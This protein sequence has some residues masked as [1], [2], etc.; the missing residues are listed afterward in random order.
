MT[1]RAGAAIA[2]W[3]AF[4]SACFWVVSR[5][6]YTADLSAFLPRTPTQEQQLLID[7]LKSG[8]ASRLILI[9]IEGG[10][11]ATRAR[12]SRAL[13]ARLRADPQFLN[14]ANGETLGLERDRQFLLENRYLLSPAV[15]ADRFTVEGLRAGVA[16]SID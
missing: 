3:L 12:A 5:A 9:G 11:Q 14:I 7:Q 1:G 4:L 16:D 13:A 2:L 6:N 15:T 10:D 8:I